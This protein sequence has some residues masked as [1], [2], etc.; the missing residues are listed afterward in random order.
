MTVSTDSATP[1][2]LAGGKI[3]QIVLFC[4]TRPN[5]TILSILRQPRPNGQRPEAVGG[6][7]GPGRQFCVLR[8]NGDRQGFD[9]A[10]HDIS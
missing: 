2:D 9:A 6:D 10:N 3:R 7:L 5:Y 4:C 1:V 8:G